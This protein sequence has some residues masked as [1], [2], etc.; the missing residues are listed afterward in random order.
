M[1]KKNRITRQVPVRARNTNDSV[2][3]DSGTGSMEAAEQQSLGAEDR[4]QVPA[5]LDA[6]GTPAAHMQPARRRGRAGSQA[7]AGYTNPPAQSPDELA[8]ASVLPLIGMV[9]SQDK[10]SRMP[11]SS[12]QLASAWQALHVRAQNSFFRRVSNDRRSSTK[13]S[14]M[15]QGHSGFSRRISGNQP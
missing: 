12:R 14:D 11:R 8:V 10:A 4:D 15:T 3:E 5:D 6:T 13:T 9:R 2:S 7:P 1:P